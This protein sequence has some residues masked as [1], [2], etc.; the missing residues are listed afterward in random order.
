MER[1]PVCFIFSSGPLG[2]YNTIKP[3]S[4]AIVAKIPRGFSD[5]TVSPPPSFLLFLLF[6]SATS[7]SSNLFLSPSTFL[8]HL[9]FLAVYIPHLFIIPFFFCFSIH[10]AGPPSFFLSS[11]FCLLREASASS[12]ASTL[13]SCR[14][15]VF[16]YLHLPIDLSF[17]FSISASSPSLT[18]LP[19]IILPPSL[20]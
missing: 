7:F 18:F 3:R 6:S 13:W 9:V 17:P 16:L 8:N 5:R 12:T 1:S 15:F 14:R 19:S 10:D 4:P 20:R 2:H 11:C